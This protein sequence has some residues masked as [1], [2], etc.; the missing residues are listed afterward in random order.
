MG[1]FGAQSVLEQ[2]QVVVRPGDLIKGVTKDILIIAVGSVNYATCLDG[3]NEFCVDHGENDRIST[4]QAS[5]QANLDAHVLHIIHVANIASDT[6]LASVTANAP[7]CTFLGS[8][9][10]PVL[11]TD[12]SC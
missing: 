6:V 5:G 8:K 1:A 11:N 9:L 7:V 4:E 3:P 12:A 10:S 2:G